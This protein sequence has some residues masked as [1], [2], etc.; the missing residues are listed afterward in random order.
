MKYR[1]AIEREDYSDYASGRVLY[2]APGHPA[3]PVRLASEAFQRCLSVRESRGGHGPCL[4]YD[5]CCGA[6]THL[7]TLGFLHGDAIGEIIASDIDGDILQLAERN[8]GLLTPAGLAGR[9]D[10]I[11]R[12]LS[13]YGKPS[14]EEALAGAKR[15]RARFRKLMDGRGVASKTFR[16]DAGN[17]D[18][19]IRGL[20][21]RKADVVFADVPY[22]QHSAWQTTG[23]AGAAG[24]DP[25]WRMLEALRPVLSEGAVVVIASDKGQRPAHNGYR[26]TERFQV[27]R[28]RIT[29]LQ[30]AG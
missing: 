11:T 3:F 26:R 15:L 29:M 2:S 19:L 5:P 21:R 13:Q 22:G 10:E 7:T 30:P 12:M 24:A 6:A 1:F 25:L 18:A 28:R 8:L 27:G 9:I 14:H 17:G 23:D 16:A 4:L 20:G